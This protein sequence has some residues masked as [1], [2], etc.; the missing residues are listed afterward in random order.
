[1]SICNANRFA[2]APHGVRSEPPEEKLMNTCV[3]R[4]KGSISIYIEGSW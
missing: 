4:M 1:M 2:D 3:R